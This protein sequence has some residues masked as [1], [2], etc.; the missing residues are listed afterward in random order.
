MTKKFLK[1]KI[2]IQK[3]PIRRHVF[4]NRPLFPP[5]NLTELNHQTRRTL[6]SEGLYL[7]CARHV[8]FSQIYFVF[9]FPCC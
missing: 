5:G 9:V 7:K 6:P 4:D 1:W 3:F 2:F 8:L